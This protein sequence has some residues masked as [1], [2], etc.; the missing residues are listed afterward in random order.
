MIIVFLKYSRILIYLENIKK[1]GVAEFGVG[2]LF[3]CGGF[4]CLS[5]LALVLGFLGE[6]LNRCQSK[7]LHT[8]LMRKMSHFLVFHIPLSYV[9][10]F[11]SSPYKWYSD[12]IFLISSTPHDI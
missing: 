4:V 2:F 9:Y 1:Y 11:S 5:G 3:I 6:N 7:H 8:T 10:L 12:I